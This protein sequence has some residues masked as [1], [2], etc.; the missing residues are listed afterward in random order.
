LC[1]SR[2]YLDHREARP[3]LARREE[4]SV[5]MAPQ[6][7]E[8]SG[9]FD[10]AEVGVLT[11]YLDFGAIR[12]AP[13]PDMQI[14]ADVD[15]STK[16]MISLTVEVNKHRMQLQAFAATRS[17]GLW[18]QTMDAL[19]KGIESQSGTVE[20]RSGAM[21]P[22]LHAE[23]PVVQ[24]EKTQTRKSIFIGCD[25]P[26]WFLRG[27]ISAPQVS[28]EVYQELISVFRS[29]VVSR[30]EL[31]MPPGDLLPLKLPTGQDG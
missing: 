26:R 10:A 29:T 8:Q 17:E 31:P 24:G 11:P 14:R 25:G 19:R 30:G 7:R 18:G 1:L 16:R 21:G 4:V 23:V 22:E 15:E 13:R 2:N 9:P 28:A 5:K 27:V 3:D 12:L 6:D 20:E